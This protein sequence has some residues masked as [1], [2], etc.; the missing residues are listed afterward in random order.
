[1]QAINPTTTSAWSKLVELSEKQQTSTIAGL[2]DQPNRF[3]RYSRSLQDILV[4]FR[5]RNASYRDYY[6]VKNHT[7]ARVFQWKNFDGLGTF[8][9]VAFSFSYEPGKVN[10]TKNIVIHKAK[11]GLI[12]IDADLNTFIPELTKTNNLERMFFYLPN[13]GKYVTESK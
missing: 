1:M 8:D 13:Q 4:D 10:A 6:F 7:P 12:P 2:F 11:I 3:E 9:A 5:I